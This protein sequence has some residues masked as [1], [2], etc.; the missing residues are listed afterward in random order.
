MKSKLHSGLTAAAYVLALALLLAAAAFAAGTPAGAGS[1][2]LAFHSAAFLFFFFPPA[3]L[4]YRIL[5][6]IRRK[7]RLLLIVSLVFYAFGQWQ[8]LPLLLLS[9][10]MNYIAGNA[11]A[12]GVGRKPVLVLTLALNLLGLGC[13]KYMNFFADILSGLLSRPLPRADLLL[14]MGISFFTFK[15]MS[16][17]ID[18][19]RGGP[20]ARRFSDALLY[21][22][23]FPQV[24]AG[25]ITRY[26]WFS[27]R[28]EERAASPEQTARGLRRFIIGLGKKLLISALAAPVASAAFSLG[29]ELDV[30]TAWL[31]AAAYTVQIYFDFSGYSDMA[32]GLGA[33]F[34]FAAPENFMYPYAASSITDF[35]RRWHISLSQ[36]FRDYLYIPLG[37]GRRGSVRKA[38]NKAV[39]FLLCGLWHGANW[40][41]L[42]WGAWHGLFSALESLRVI[43]CKKLARS[44]P[45]RVLCH[46]YTLLVVCLGFVIFRA[47][48]L[49]Q[50]ME[51]FRALFTGFRLTPA[52]TLAI[53]RI[54]P[55]SWCA[56][57]SGCVLCLPIAPALNARAENLAAVPGRILR[58]C[59]FAGAAALFLL[60]LMA[61]AG[62]SFEPFIYAQ[63]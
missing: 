56:L 6:G 41:F 8:G 46:A 19:Y 33:V 12:R 24:T 40:T 60:C 4:L 49:S 26:A 45:G 43:D 54:S 5:P 55:A 1:A 35:W 27:G 29:G 44:A 10:L 48:D 62:G 15:G 52:S 18:I 31:G 21:I 3:F 38:L 63:F 28:L 25:P 37:G 9:A 51:M 59:S 7:N 16:Y 42:L 53:R 30:R 57:L 50:A 61:A 22:S 2:D 17:V 34:G 23:F 47:A 58:I 39:V 14:P 36:W 32:I 11:V 20:P 13:F